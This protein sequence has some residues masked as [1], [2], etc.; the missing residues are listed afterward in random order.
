MHVYV[1]VHNPL[2]YSGVHWPENESSSL[3]EKREQLAMDMCN[4]KRCHAFFS[5]SILSISI[6]TANN[7]AHARYGRAVALSHDCVL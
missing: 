7:I 6:I 1:P 2:K 4:L 5:S 3:N